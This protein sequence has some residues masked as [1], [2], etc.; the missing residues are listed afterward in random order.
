MRNP[1]GYGSVKKLK[2]NRRR[3]YIAVTPAVYDIKPKKDISFL[4]DAL[5]EDLYNKVQEYYDSYYESEIQ[6]AKQVQ[7]TIGYYESKEDA[8]IALADYN[9]NPYD[10][11]KRNTTFEQIY[12]VLYEEKFA[13]MKPQAKK[14]YTTS[15][16]KCD[17][18]KNMRMN[19]IRK[20][21]MQKIINDHSNMS[22]STL[23]NI[24]VLFHA[25]FNFALENDVCDKDYSQFVEVISEK[26]TKEKNP[27]THEE[28]GILWD[29][30]TDSNWIDSI[31][32][33][34]YTGMRITELL[35]LSKKDIHIKER[36]IAL[37]GT[38][39]EAADRLVPI[40]K[41]IIPLLEN[42]MKCN[43]DYIFC[44]KYNQPISYPYYNKIY[45]KPAMRLLNIEHTTHDCRH[46]FASFAAASKLNPILV[47]KIIGHS[48]QD[49]TQD[50]YTHSSVF[51]ETLIEEIDN[52][53]I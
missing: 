42:R 48:A 34:I 24:L 52:L 26:Q 38:K 1:N 8:M 22:K 13:K 31:L 32:I 2:G 3:P 44:K 49:I 29:K 19:E 28:V 46:T 47:K 43:C 45:F 16:S 4:K 50:T 15:F 23:N 39:T 9:K 37:K 30:M 7:K 18:I 20:H 35:T 40:H 41:K 12:N 53:E 6:K 10:I 27:F 14:A 36:Y 21:H 17:P 51:I 5:P 33:L 25:V 11:D